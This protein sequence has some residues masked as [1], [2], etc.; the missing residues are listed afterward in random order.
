MTAVVEV[1]AEEVKVEVEAVAD[2]QVVATVMLHFA[3][4]VKPTR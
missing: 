3:V 1:A 2:I 4:E